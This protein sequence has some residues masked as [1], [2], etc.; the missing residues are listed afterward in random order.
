MLNKYGPDVVTVLP[1][2]AAAI[3]TAPATATVSTLN[4]GNLAT[5]SFPALS[6]AMKKVFSNKNAQLAFLEA[7]VA[8]I[9]RHGSAAQ[10]KAKPQLLLLKTVCSPPLHQ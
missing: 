4:A 7:A 10:M 1:S 3:F 8:P 5:R 9:M 6:T 2:L